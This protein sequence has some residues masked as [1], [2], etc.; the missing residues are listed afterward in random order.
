MSKIKTKRPVGRPR[1]DGGDQLSR[2]KLLAATAKL[3]A[4]NGYTGTSFRMIAA[5]LDVTTASIF[6]LYASKDK[7]LSSLIA[8]STKPFLLFYEELLS[9]DLSPQVALYKSIFE[10]AKAV[11]SFDREH[12]STFNMPELRR[13]EFAD[14]QSIRKKM[15]SHYQQLI[16]QG[17][18]NGDFVLSDATWT[19]EQ[20]FQLTETSALIDENSNKL[21]IEKRANITS[22]FCLRGLLVDP[23]QLEEIQRAQSRIDARINLD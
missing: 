15:V 10:E 23:V 17:W 19:A 11:S 7:L 6:H 12:V 4:A 9:L 5:E 1:S 21:T 16:E 14:V 3:M 2:G 13:P 22:E 20:I 18:E 8:E